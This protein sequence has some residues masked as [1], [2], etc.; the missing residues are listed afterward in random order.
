MQVG[1]GLRKGTSGQ[2]WVWILFVFCILPTKV[3]ALEVNGNISSDTT[4]SASDSPVNINVS[5]FEVESGATLTIDAGVTVRVPSSG[6]ITITG[7]LVANGT[8]S[9][10]ITFTPQSGTWEYIDFTNS[11]CTP[12]NNAIYWTNFNSMSYDS[13]SP[14]IVSN[15]NLTMEN[16]AITATGSAIYLVRTYANHIINQCDGSVILR[17]NQLN[18][19][20]SSSSSYRSAAIYIDGTDLTLSGN[21]IT[22]TSSG[23]SGI[24]GVYL[25][26]SN[27]LGYNVSI[28][29]NTINVEATNSSMEYTSGIYFNSGASGNPTNNTL[30]IQGKAITYGIYKGSG[31]ISGNTLTVSSNSSRGTYTYGIYSSSASQDDSVSNNQV[32]VSAA[33]G[34]TYGIY[35]QASTFSKNRVIANLNLS[36]SYGSL[37]GIYNRYYATTIINNSVSLGTTDA[38]IYTCGICVGTHYAEHTLTIKNNALMGDGGTHST[39]IYNGSE[40]VTANNTYNLVYNFATAYDGT[41]AGTGSLSSDPL[42][43]D[44]DSDLRLQE[45]SPAIDAGDWD[46]DVG[47]EP[48]NHGGRINMGADGGMS[49]ARNSSVR[50]IAPEITTNDGNDYSTTNPSI[51]LTGRTAKTTTTILLNGSVIS[52]EDLTLEYTAGESSWTYSGTLTEGLNTFSFT[53][54]DQDD[55]TSNAASINITYTIDAS[56]SPTPTPTPEPT[57]TP[58]TPDNPETP[59]TPGTPGT[60]GEDGGSQMDATSAAGGCS[61]ANPV[62]EFEPSMFWLV[63]TLAAFLFSSLRESTIEWPYE[64]NP[65]S[66]GHSTPR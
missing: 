61:L 1:E 66:D 14:F 31:S 57:E 32:T 52:T 4:W 18:F 27:T 19:T 59:D 37:S 16:S 5:N 48:A 12:N 55:N 34:N 33:N 9:Q 45:G 36:G 35:G 23:T 11:A 49:S 60:E 22:V 3:F 63:F 7:T 26:S 2:E 13:V 29:S 58:E 25:N 46:D 56:P 39:G 53:A 50:I 21:T 38:S 43:V 41:S 30:T 42:F 62:H 15:T 10:N 65:R 6:H 24:A 17:N 54:R 40:N 44:A 51:T 47:S 28:D 20:T 64:K 8:S